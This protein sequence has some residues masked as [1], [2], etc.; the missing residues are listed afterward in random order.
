M[1][2]NKGEGIGKKIVEG[3]LVSFVIMGLF[4]LLQLLIA[5]V[6]VMAAVTAGMLET[7]MDAQDAQR[8]AMQIVMDGNYM[9]LLTVVSTFAMAVFSVPAYWLVWGRHKTAQDKQYFRKQVL[10]LRTFSMIVIGCVGLYYLALLIAAVIAVASP[11]TM[12][13]P[14]AF[15]TK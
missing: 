6:G 13:M 2:Y 10:R 11:Q 5:L 3:L 12:G 15:L 4:F 1:E 8:A 9:T 7:G 14:W